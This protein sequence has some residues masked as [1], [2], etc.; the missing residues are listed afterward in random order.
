MNKR[1]TKPVLEIKLKTNQ[2]IILTGKISNLTNSELDNKSDES[3]FLNIWFV[4]NNKINLNAI[5]C[6]LEIFL[7][8]IY[9]LFIIIIYNFILQFK[10]FLQFF[11]ILKELKNNFTT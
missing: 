8:Y 7:K 4:K 1:I 3:I 2:K 5:L 11:Y 6:S 10:K 9:D